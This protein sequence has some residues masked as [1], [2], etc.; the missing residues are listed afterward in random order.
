MCACENRAWWELFLLWQLL[1]RGWVFSRGRGGSRGSEAGRASIYGVRPPHG[2]L[3]TWQVK[4]SAGQWHQVTLVI[5]PKLIVSVCEKGKKGP[6][7]P[8]RSPCLLPPSCTLR[9]F[10]PRSHNFPSFYGALLASK[11]HSYND[12]RITVMISRTFDAKNKKK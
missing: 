6:G 9:L 10:R 1:G 4:V 5:C 8:S 3:E 7:L 12:V 11:A 2:D